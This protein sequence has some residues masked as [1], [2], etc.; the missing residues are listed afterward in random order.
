MGMDMQYHWRLRPPGERLNV[1]LENHQPGQ[2]R[3]FTAAL[4]SANM[5]CPVVTCGG[6]RA[7]LDDSPHHH[8]HSFSGLPIVVEEM[9]RV[10]ASPEP[11]LVNSAFAP[12]SSGPLA[13]ANGL[14]PSLRDRQLEGVADR[15]FRHLVLGRLQRLQL[16]GLEVR[17][18]E[19]RWRIGEPQSLPAEGIVEVHRPRF[20]RR[21]AVGGS[22]A[23]AES[24]IQGDWDSP[25]LPRLLARLARSSAAMSGV[26]GTAGRLMRPLL[27][28]RIG[29]A[30]TLGQAVVATLALTTI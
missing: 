28:L 24:F 14:A 11:C 17:Q 1:V 29:S 23:A 20:Y 27:A 9:S 4:A 2:G 19:Q 26:N 12:E 5:S 13:T 8:R 6:W 16:D 21:L 22:L 25:D 7:I 10:S 30:A 15:C 18:G 3:L